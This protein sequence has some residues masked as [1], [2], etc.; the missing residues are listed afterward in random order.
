[1][2]LITFL[3]AKQRSGENDFFVGKQRPFSPNCFFALTPSI[4]INVDVK[5]AVEFQKIL[6][7]F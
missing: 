4:S 2:R 1:M 7:I 6:Q 5:L 3:R